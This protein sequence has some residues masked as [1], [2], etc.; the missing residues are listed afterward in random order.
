[1]TMLAIID[2]VIRPV[3]KTLA[4]LV[5]ASTAARGHTELSALKP[6]RV[7]TSNAVLQRGQSCPIFGRDVPGSKVTVRFGG[8]TLNATADASGHWRVNLAPLRVCTTPQ[9]LTVDASTRLSLTNILVGDVWL[10]SGQSNADWPL[11]S[12]AGGR[13][14]MASATNTLLRYLQMT[15]SPITTATAWTP[16]EV[17]KLNPD[18]YFSGVWQVSDP[19]SAGAVSAVGY[20]FARHIQTN[21]NLPIG[22]IDCTVGGTMAESWMPTEAINANS[23]LKAIA[24]NFLDSDMVPVFANTR[25]RQNLANWDAAGRPAPMPEHPYKPGACWRNGLATIAPYALC[26]VLWYQGETDADFQDPSKYDTMAEWHT[27]TFK[28]LVAAWRKAWENAA[29]PVYSVQLPRLDR[30]SWPWFRESQL[31]CAQTIPHTAMAV[32]FD[33][34]DPAN[35]HPVHKQPVADRIARIA[36]AR[37]YGENL[38]WSGPQLRSWRIQGSSIVLQ[39]DHAESGLVSSDGHALKLFTVAGANRRFFPATATISNHALIVSAPQVS[40]PVAARYAW[41]PTGDINF[42]NGAGLPASPFRTDDWTNQDL[43][44]NTP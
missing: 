32:A 33:C 28:A 30:P 38:E 29:L 9:T 20:L 6:A 19:A 25:L 12:A 8:Q 39:F 22:L 23:R 18:D 15:E 43:G 27:E 31:K 37:T 16:A 2:N 40:R 26:G 11:R 5:A 4:V 42:Y 41:V 7:F 1:M 17:A 21:Q 14:A 24:D 34:G 44:S 3:V 13:A 10:I 36:R 35:V